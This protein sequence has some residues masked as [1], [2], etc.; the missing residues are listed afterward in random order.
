MLT[1]HYQYRNSSHY[2]CYNKNTITILKPDPCRS[3]QTTGDINS[4][5]KLTH[6]IQWHLLTGNKYT[7]KI[8]VNR[9][10][11]RKRVKRGITE[12]YWY[13][14]SKKYWNMKTR[15]FSVAL[16]KMMNLLIS[17]T[18]ERYIKNELKIDCFKFLAVWIKANKILCL[19]DII[20][21]ASFLILFI[22]SKKNSG[23]WSW[24]PSRWN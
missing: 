22:F 2:G 20:K 5:N 1:K 14:I 11:E 18:E 7:N 17:D 9:E 23:C 3:K 24:K 16:K 15:F 13:F 19:I 21:F 8:I 10:R 4:R 6:Q 12:C